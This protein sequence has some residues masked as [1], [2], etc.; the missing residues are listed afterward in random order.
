[1][2]RRQID[3]KFFPYSSHPFNGFGTGDWSNFGEFGTSLDIASSVAT[4]RPR[5][6][7]SLIFS[8]NLYNISKVGLY[9][10]NL[11]LDES[12]DL[13]FD[14]VNKKPSNFFTVTVVAVSDI[15]RNRKLLKAVKKTLQRKLNPRKNR[16]RH[17]A[18]LK[19]S[20]LTHEIKVY[21]FKQVENV[22]FGVYS[23]T[24]NKRKVYKSLMEDKERVYNYIARLVLDKIPFEKAVNRISLTI[25]KSKG[26]KEIIE[27]NQYIIRQLKGRIDPKVPMNIE[28]KKSHEHAGIQIADVFGWGVYRKYEKKDDLWYNI[29]KEK[30]RF[31]EVFLQ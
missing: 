27:F 26:R 31:D 9:M 29:F 2:L 25:D 23:I 18:E 7:S 15:K 16:T 21:F 24:L 22:Q 12:G 14:F 19:G 20:S 13:G 3:R 8:L 30:I 17:V 28:H 6:L 10:W 11:Y 5:K 1:M 4:N